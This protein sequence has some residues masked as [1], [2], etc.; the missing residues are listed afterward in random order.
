MIQL[1][2]VVHH[3][4]DRDGLTEI[5]VFPGGIGADGFLPPAALRCVFLGLIRIAVSFPAGFFKQGDVDLRRQDQVRGSQ[6][7]RHPVKLRQPGG[8][9]Q[10]LQD[11]KPFVQLSHHRPVHHPGKLFLLSR[12]QSAVGI[13][14][15]HIVIKQL[16]FLR[17]HGDIS[18]IIAKQ[19]FP[20][21]PVRNPV[22][23]LLRNPCRLLLKP[24]SKNRQANQRCP[25]DDPTVYPLPHSALP[26]FPVSLPSRSRRSF[27]PSIPAG[28]LS[29]E[30]MP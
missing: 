17:I 24:D 15:E 20:V 25:R 29:V 9:H 26:F 5:L 28:I 21:A 8:F 14:D 4:Y 2:A 13:N 12:R 22:R 23:I 6:L 11:G 1:K 16:L 10:D 30:N 27:F 19:K 3:A 18:R 7:L